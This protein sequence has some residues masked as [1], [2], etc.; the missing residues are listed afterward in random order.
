MILCSKHEVS[1][2]YNLIVEDG[3]HAAHIIHRCNFFM[4]PPSVNRFFLSP[5]F[6]LK[7]VHVILPLWYKLN[8]NGGIQAPTYTQISCTLWFET[9]I[10]KSLRSILASN[11]GFSE[12]YVKI[13]VRIP[14]WVFNSHHK[15]YVICTYLTLKTRN[16]LMCDR[17][18]HTSTQVHDFH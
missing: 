15:R 4:W 16:Q 18:I 6:R 2:I 14:Q 7:Y 5:F 11:Q 8:T 1:L 9:N 3:H 12:F 13:R 17:W 10:L